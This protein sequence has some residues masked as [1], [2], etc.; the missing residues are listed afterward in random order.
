ME[1]QNYGLAEEWKQYRKTKTL[2][3]E[4]LEKYLAIFKLT[5]EQISFIYSDKLLIYS[6]TFVFAQLSI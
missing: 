1:L 6:L 3:I 2:R 4:L 5:I